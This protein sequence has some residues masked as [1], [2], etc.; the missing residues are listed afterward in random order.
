MLKDAQDL[1]FAEADPTYDVE[2]IDTAHKLAILMTMAYG[3]NITHDEIVTEGIS[4]IEPVDIEFAREF[5]CRIK[6]LAISR[7]HGDHVE[8][9]VHPTMVPNS[10]LLA[11]ISGAYNAVHFNGDMVG[12]VLL[13]GQGAGKMPTGSAVAADVMDIARDIAAGSVGRVPSLFYL[14]ENIKDRAVTPLNQLACPY[15]FRFTALD[16][17]G[18]LA[19]VSTVLSRHGISIESVIQKGRE[20]GGQSPLLCRRILLSNQQSPRLWS[21]LTLW[22]LSPRLLCGLRCW[23]RSRGT[24]P[25]KGRAYMSS[26]IRSD[27]PNLMRYM[28]W[29]SEHCVQSV[30]A[31]GKQVSHH[32]A[33]GYPTAGDQPVATTIDN[34]YEKKV[35]KRKTLLYITLILLFL[36]A[37]LVSADEEVTTLTN[38]TPLTGITAVRHVSQRYRINVPSNTEVLTISASGGAGYGDM[39]VIAPETTSFDCRS[40][41]M[42]NRATCTLN[43]PLTGQHYIRIFPY[44]A[45]TGVTL[46]ACYTT[47]STTNQAPEVN[48]GADQAITLPVDTVNLDGT[49]TDDGLPGPPGMVN[50]IWSKIS[51]PGTVTFGDS[52]S[53]DTT[54]TFSHAG[55]YQLRLTADDGALNAFDDTIITVNNGSTADALTNCT[56][57]NDI[58]SSAHKWKYYYI[59]VPADAGRL[60]VNTR[61]G[62]GGN[63][64]GINGADLYVK[65]GGK[66]S[67]GSSD[68]SSA[69]WFNNEGCAV[70]TLSAGRY[71]IGIYAD[72][73]YSNVTLTA[74]YTASCNGGV[75][76]AP[77]VNAGPDQT[78]TLPDNTVT[79]HGTIT[80]DGLP[81][82]PRSVRLT[83]SKVSGP[84]GVTIRRTRDLETN[85]IF[86]VAGTY[87]LRLSADDGILESFDEVTI[88]VNAETINQSPAV[89]AGADQTIT[90][91]ADT[92]NLD[93][94]ITDDG[95][96]NP[97]GS[98]STAWSKISG[99]GTVIF[100]SS[101][102][103]DT[104]AIF[105]VAG[106]YLLRLTAD[107]GELI[108][109]DDITVTVSTS[110]NVLTNCTPLTGITA[111]LHA[112]QHYTIDVP[113]D[114]ESLTVQTSGGTGDGD[115]YVKFNATPTTTSFDCRPF[116]SGNREA[117][118]FSGLSTG[119]YHV[120]IYPYSA[121][122]GV[123]LEACYTTR[124][125][126]NQAPVVNAG[127]DQAITLPVDT[128]SLDGTVTDDSLPDP[129]GSLS[130]TWSKVSGPGTA[131]FGN[132]TNPDTTVSFSVA[133]TYMLRLSADDGEQSTSDD[134]TVIINSDRILLVNSTPIA[135]SVNYQEWK[136]YRITASSTDMQLK[137]KMTNLSADVD[138]YVRRGGEPTL[139]V[140]DCRPYSGGAGPETCTLT[141]SGE[142]EWYISVYGYQSGNFTLEAVLS[143]E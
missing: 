87:V 82:P 99:P 110:N 37:A 19:A 15:Y 65:F 107:D 43:N 140:Y 11:S 72:T 129:P 27:N 70:R 49:V 21:R 96:P 51:G 136:E 47:G 76:E 6:L 13:Y 50:T 86:S 3:M 29:R 104:T 74:I 105:S 108:A 30:G 25:C 84:D 135:S 138:L 68:C 137:V 66:P 126:F 39:Y 71:Y 112:W 42:G 123:S 34:F 119:Q 75:N 69:M 124:G 132:I 41:L 102:S 10:H 54:A 36:S 44:T 106:T 139:S 63:S 125:S 121:I 56:T 94:T 143:R 89:N 53:A 32:W 118:S 58:N 77:S 45:I 23:R 52:N 92:V 142:N 113:A 103:A 64:G 131:I 91:P 2:G 60:M 28:Q 109:S 38:C 101:N 90:L 31:I 4:G 18:V 55:T 5:G 46:E 62:G 133:G 59:D 122:A 17:P 115:L 114:A 7:N 127:V 40:L 26:L 22:R 93:G 130:V 120:S 95:L 8:A 100:G 111:A 12:N 79:L 1:G 97:P 83:W 98:V 48:A 33:G 117:C 73:S 67:R 81:D 116:T 85:V 128:V 20:E 80:D 16:Q 57:V 9:R 35:M 24:A 61:S 88:T 134:I 141:N 14:P 78:I